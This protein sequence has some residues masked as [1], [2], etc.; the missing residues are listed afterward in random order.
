LLEIPALN[1]VTVDSALFGLYADEFNAFDALPGNVVTVVLPADTNNDGSV[2]I[3]DLNNVRNNFGLTGQGIVGDTNADGV[4]D[5]G[6]LNSVRG[7]FGSA[8]V[9]P[10]PEP[11]TLSIAV[12]A[13]GLFTLAGARKSHRVAACGLSSWQRKC[14]AS[15]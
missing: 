15:R 3:H 9:R 2:D 6:D 10:V 14:V 1:H 11:A 4:V 7:F 8:P 5:I 12:V 13:L